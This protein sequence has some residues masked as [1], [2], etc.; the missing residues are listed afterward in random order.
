MGVKDDGPGKT[1]KPTAEKPSPQQLMMTG[2]YVNGF[3]EPGSGVS[4]EKRSPL[5]SKD[6]KKRLA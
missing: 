3:Q 1:D 2:S 5:T 6:A 4:T